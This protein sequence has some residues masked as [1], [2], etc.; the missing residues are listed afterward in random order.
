MGAQCNYSDNNIFPIRSCILFTTCYSYKCQKERFV[1]LLQ[2]SNVHFQVHKELKN[3]IQKKMIK[4]VKIKKPHPQR[5]N[6]GGKENR[7]FLVLL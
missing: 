3:I 5:I 2:Y 1:K 6:T 7:I 4:N